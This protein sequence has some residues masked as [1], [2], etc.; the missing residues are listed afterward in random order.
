MLGNLLA[1]LDETGKYADEKK[2]D[3]EELLHSAWHQ[4]SST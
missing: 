3:V 1:I 2:F 4:T